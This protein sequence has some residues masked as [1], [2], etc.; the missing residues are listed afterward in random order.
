VVLVCGLIVFNAG[1]VQGETSD[2]ITILLDKVPPEIKIIVNTAKKLVGIFSG[3]S[4]S[5]NVGTT[6]LRFLEIIP[7]TEEPGRIPFFRL[8]FQQSKG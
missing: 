7:G 4:E 2:P 1:R 5:I 8:G 3:V 6:I